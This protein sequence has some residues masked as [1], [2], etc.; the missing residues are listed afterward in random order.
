MGFAE[1]LTPTP[2][3]SPPASHEQA[4]ASLERYNARHG[5]HTVSQAGSMAADERGAFDAGGR[6]AADP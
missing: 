1:G 3:G 2:I 4:R 6:A 5:A